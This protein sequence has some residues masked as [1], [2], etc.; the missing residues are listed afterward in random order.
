M[1]KY[2][3]SAAAF[4]SVLFHSATNT[5]FMHLQTKSYAQHKALQKYYEAIVDLT[6]SY[7]EAYQ[8]CYDIIT[9]Y[10]K[11]FHLATEPV[12]YLTQ[13]KEFV[14]DIRKDL[15]SESQLQNIV[16]EIADQI[17]ST[18]YKLRFLK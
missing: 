17:D 5:H 4:V 13:I 9:N 1:S 12:K 6:D 16:D 8:G 7:A 14:D 11:D 2:N 18:L 15:P 10:P 3:E